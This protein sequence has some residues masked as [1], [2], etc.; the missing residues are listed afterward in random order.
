MTLFKKCQTFFDQTSMRFHSAMATLEPQKY[1]IAGTVGTEI[2]LLVS[3][4]LVFFSFFAIFLNFSIIKKLF[5]A[6]RPY[7]NTMPLNCMAKNWRNLKIT[8][9]VRELL[10]QYCISKPL[11][12]FFCRVFKIRC[13]V[14]SGI[15]PQFIRF[16]LATV[17]MIHRSAK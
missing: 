7:S 6:P 15:F 1:V 13:F 5:K 11:V 16:L 4:R 9:G 10:V 3:A 12:E 8:L 17:R 2:I 14:P